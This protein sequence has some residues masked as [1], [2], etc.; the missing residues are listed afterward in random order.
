M[1]QNLKLEI[2]Q[3]LDNLTEEKFI[4]TWI[5][6]F[7]SKEYKKWPDFINKLNIEGDSNFLN[8]ST[9]Q[10]CCLTCC[11]HSNLNVPEFRIMDLFYIHKSVLADYFIIYVNSK[12]TAIRNN[13]EIKYPIAAIISPE[14]YYKEMFAFAVDQI[15]TFYPDGKII[16]YHILT[17]KIKQPFQNGSTVFDIFFGYE[18]ISRFT[19]IEN[20]YYSG[21]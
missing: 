17:S 7:E 15:K 18:D 5:N 6:K 3:W 11:A 21:E 20:K 8:D 12:F 1:H 19:P 9:S 10:N 2:H 4:K 16:P 13:Q 14:G